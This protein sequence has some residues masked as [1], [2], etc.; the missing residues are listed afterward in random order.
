MSLCDYEQSKKIDAQGYHFIALIM[1]AMRQADSSNLEQLRF[2]FPEVYAEF[3]A[4]YNA[5]GGVLPRE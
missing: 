3:I 2:A 1:A 4:R 5:P